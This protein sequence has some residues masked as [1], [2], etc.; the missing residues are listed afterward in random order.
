[1]KIYLIRHAQ[2]EYNIAEATVHQKVGEHYESSP[3][4]YEVKYSQKNTD[5]GITSLGVQQSLVPR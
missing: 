1:M 3:E 5:C 4:F 2:S